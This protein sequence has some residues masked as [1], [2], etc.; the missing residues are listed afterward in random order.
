MIKQKEK[1]KQNNKAFRISAKNLFLTYSQIDKDLTKEYIL[2][3]L[4]KKLS[5]KN[6]LISLEDHTE[7]G[8]HSHILLQLNKKCNIRNKSILDIKFNNKIYHGNYQRVNS[9]SAVIQYVIKDGNFINNKEFHIY[10]NSNNELVNLETYVLQSARRIGINNALNEFIKLDE[11]LALKKIDK[12]E[13]NI[14]K[15]LKIES[16]VNEEDINVWPFKTKHIDADTLPDSIQDYEQT[17]RLFNNKAIAIVGKAGTGKS[18]LAKTIA[19]EHSKKPL[20]IKH[21]EGI[22]EYDSNKHD[23]IVFDDANLS[24]LKTEQDIINFLDI[25]T[26]G[27]KTNTRHL[28]GC[29]S[30]NKDTPII[31]TVNDLRQLFHNLTDQINRRLTIVKLNQ[32]IQ[33]SIN[34][35]NSL[36]VI[37]NKHTHIYNNKEEMLKNKQA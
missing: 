1:Q 26:K 2:N 13:K 23:S 14:K 6:Y 28:Y 37:F 8:I 21:Y 32:P 10:S 24:Q 27:I 9:L 12:L 36:K 16:D 33:L 3:E 15:I 11:N 20:F 29:K 22:K 34:I 4:L 7:H 19:Y 30:I 25:V 18:F 35:D 17:K 5:I 31:M